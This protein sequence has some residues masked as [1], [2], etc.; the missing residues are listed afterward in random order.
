[1]GKRYIYIYRG[2]RKRQVG[3]WSEKANYGVHEKGERREINAWNF[4]H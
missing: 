1:M 2:G 3:A 4:E